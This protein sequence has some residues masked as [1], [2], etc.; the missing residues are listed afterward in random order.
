MRIKTISTKKSQTTQPV[1]FTDEPMAAPVQPSTHAV[2]T[3]VTATELREWVD[4]AKDL[5]DIRWSK[6]QAM[7]EA[8]RTETFN[9][10]ERLAGLADK[11]PTELLDYL[12]KLN[13]RE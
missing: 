7:R 4:R 2:P 8:I 11:F 13:E 9:E 12:G 5:P 10:N 6:V 1:T 3:P